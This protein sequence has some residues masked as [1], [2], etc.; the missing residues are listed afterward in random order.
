M[1]DAPNALL[2]LQIVHFFIAYLILKHVLLKP[3]LKVLRNIDDSDR[4]IKRDLALLEEE[5]DLQNA[6]VRDQW[7]RH[8]GV[9]R[10]RMPLPVKVVVAERVRAEPVVVSFGTVDE[11]KLMTDLKDVLVEHVS[12]GN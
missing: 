10:S 1:I 6:L 5:V 12:G 4:S 11:K 9:L 2:L 7:S 3:G 8:C